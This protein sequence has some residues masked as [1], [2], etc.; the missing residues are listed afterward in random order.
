[1]TK[2][3][4]VILVT[5][6]TVAAVAALAA[7]VFN[8]RWWGRRIVAKWDVVTAGPEVPADSPWVVYGPDFTKWSIPELFQAWNKGVPG[9]YP[10]GQRPDLPTTAEILQG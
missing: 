9:W 3:N 5:G 8:K 6:L 10:K 4:K 7:T 2:R 1:M